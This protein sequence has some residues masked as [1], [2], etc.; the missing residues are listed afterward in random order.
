MLMGVLV[1]IGG[2]VL[3]L[4]G[5]ERFTD[6]AIRTAARLSVSAFY[7]GTVVSG[8]EPENLVT[9]AA[10]ATSG[11]PQVA[12]GT[13]IGSAIFMLTGGLGL[14]LLLV[15]ME[16]RIPR[17]GGVAMLLCLVPFA[18]ALWHDGTVSRWDGALLLV[19]GVGLMGW[20]Y[21]K[22]PVFLS[23]EAD[24]PSEG[25]ARLGAMAL[26]GFG[27][28]VMLVGAELVVWGVTRLLTSVRVSETF[29]GMAVVGLGESLEETARMVTPARR[30]H[31]ELAWGNVVGTV[32][33]LLAINL[34]LIALIQPLVAAPLV[35][36]FHVPYLIGCTVLVA[37]GLLGATRL[38]R[39][40]GALLVGLSLF[41]LGFN[42]WFLSASG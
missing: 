14:A 28:A 37:L 32:V 22:S 27:V 10:A 34:G 24:E 11:L 41:Y 16:V 31:P 4:W 20:L 2:I 39:V 18:V 15:P 35:L 1:L 9:G 8:F 17:A 21:R 12:L 25:A 30:G 33:I 23:P 42:L 7:V 40:M 29:L 5:A 3:V 36:R 13:V 38:G 19:V 6:G 26:L